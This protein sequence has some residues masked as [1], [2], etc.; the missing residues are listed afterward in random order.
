MG[1]TKS[2]DQRAK[3][4]GYDQVVT[5]LILLHDS[6]MVITG[7]NLESCTHKRGCS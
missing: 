5:T 7:H 2:G 3:K 1:I 4:P 6:Y